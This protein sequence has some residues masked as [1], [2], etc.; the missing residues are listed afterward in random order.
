MGYS[1]SGEGKGF[2]TCRLCA[3]SNCRISTLQPFPGSLFPKKAVSRVLYCT[4]SVPEINGFSSPLRGLLLSLFCVRQ[5]LALFLNFYTSLQL[6]FIFSLTFLTVLSQ[7]WKQNVKTSLIHFAQILGGLLN[8]KS[9]ILLSFWYSLYYCYMSTLFS[10]FSFTF[11]EIMLNVIYCC[12]IVWEI[13]ST[14]LPTPLYCMFLSLLP[15][16]KSL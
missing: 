14:L 2:D 5:F 12:S 13:S 3:P 4:G 8:Q 1:F 9:H 11:P 7:Y 15:C 16:F 10:T 6:L